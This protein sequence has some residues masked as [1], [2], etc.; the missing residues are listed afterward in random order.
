M[1]NPDDIIIEV[2]EQTTLG[3]DPDTGEDL[4]DVVIANEITVRE[5]LRGDWENILPRTKPHE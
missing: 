3:L 5:L 1:L 4:G 2:H